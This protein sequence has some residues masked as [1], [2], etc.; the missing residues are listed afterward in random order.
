[1]SATRRTRVPAAVRANSSARML[2]APR[3][4]LPSEEELGLWRW[5]NLILTM[6]EGAFRGATSQAVRGCLGSEKWRA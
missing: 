6:Y 5:E 4:A 3:T 2:L 1:M